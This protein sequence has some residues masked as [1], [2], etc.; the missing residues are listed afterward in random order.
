MLNF[1]LKMLCNAYKDV[2]KSIPGCCNM[3]SEYL[4]TN[5]GKFHYE[6]LCE[7]DIVGLRP[8]LQCDILAMVEYLANKDGVQLPE[9][10][11]KYDSVSCP[12]KENDEYIVLKESPI[13]P[14]NADAIFESMLEKS[15]EPFKRRGIPAICFDYTV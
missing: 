1:T 6:E 8:Y 7:A 12:K 5:K 11:K 4:L 2:S 9:W 3:R 15:I 13:A 14:E 10:F